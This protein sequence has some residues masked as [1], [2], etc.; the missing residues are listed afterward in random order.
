M[1]KQ[2]MIGID[3]TTQETPGIRETLIGEG[4]AAAEQ[5]AGMVGQRRIP[6]ARPGTGPDR[7]SRR[8]AHRWNYLHIVQDVVP[9]SR[10]RGFTA[11]QIDTTLV[12]STCRL[13]ENRA[14]Y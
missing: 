13:F 5:R 10:E 9:A 14:A 12:G 4:M 11:D 1:R 3:V 7:L 6:D 8:P 2:D